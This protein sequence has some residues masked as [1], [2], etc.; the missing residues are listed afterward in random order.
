MSNVDLVQEEKK[1]KTDGFLDN[2]KLR[3]NA[4][5]EAGKRFMKDYHAKMIVWHQA[6][7]AS[8]RYTDLR[9]KN[10]MPVT[11]IQEDVDTFK[12][13]AR[14][15]LFYTGRPCR[16]VGREEDDKADAE[17]KQDFM[18]YIDDQDDIYGKFGLFLR[19][20]SLYATCAANVSYDERT[21]REWNLRPIP[22]PQIDEITQQPVLD[23]N[24]EMIPAIDPQTGLLLESGDEEWVLE[25]IVIFRGATVRRIDMQNIFITIDKVSNDDQ[26]PI[27]VQS[28]VDR[29]F[30]NSQPYFINQEELETRGKA[31]TGGTQDKAKDKKGSPEESTKEHKYIEWQGWVDKKVLYKFQKS[32]KDLPIIDQEKRNNIDREMLKIAPNERTFVV[33]GLTDDEV[34]SRISEDPLKWGKPS[35]ILGVIDPE[36]DSPFG[37]GIAQMIESYQRIGENLHD[38]LYEN[39]KQSVNAMWYINT[40]VM[41]GRKELINK[42]GAIISGTVD[43][44]KAIQRI[45]QP[46][47]ATDIYLN[48]DRSREGARRAGG[49]MA[50][51]TG[52]G[53]PNAET[54]GENQIAL[55]QSNLRMRDYIR[56][57]EKSLVEKLYSLRNHIHATFIDQD[58]GFSIIGK[59]ADKWRTISPVQQRAS[60][61]FVCES[62][63]RETERA[64]IT[65]QLIQFVEIAPHAANAGQP[66]RF[67]KMMRDLGELGFSMSQEKLEEYFPLLRLERENPD[68]DYDDM[69]IQNAMA[70]MQQ[71]MVGTSTNGTGGNLPQPLTEGDALQ[72]ANARNQPNPGRLN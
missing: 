53:D 41:D 4:D 49:V 26:E 8:E 61:N 3:I 44:S 32:N 67:D 11:W 17:A 7:H 51:L 47:V 13:D 59:K 38:M 14:D 43:A 69:M 45:E 30:F 10:R 54:L 39:L 57:F 68:V 5:F 56:S 55:A 29:E 15:K 50:I 71:G 16:I 1:V 40:S 35:I 23:K 20:C 62:S 70:A 60:V 18:D 63:T 19:D 64:V 25:E 48:I 46:R 34:F 58:F 21:K 12:A 36:E 24:G 65:Q 31:T 37:R 33:V 52:Q 6:Y 66:V 9:S 42:A 22:I 72:G 2:L 27:M 28:F